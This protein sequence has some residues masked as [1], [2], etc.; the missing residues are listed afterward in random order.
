MMLCIS[1]CIFCFE[2]REENIKKK[3]GGMWLKDG[4]AVRLLNKYHKFCLFIFLLQGEK[5]EQIIKIFTLIVL[6]YNADCNCYKI[7]VKI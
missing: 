1:I 5:N 2:V 6:R 7:V 3:E 4:L